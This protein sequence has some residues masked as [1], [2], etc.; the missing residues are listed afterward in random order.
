[1]EPS[2]WTTK[3]SIRPG[4]IEAAESPPAGVSTSSIRIAAT[5]ASRGVT[6]KAVDGKIVGRPAGSGPKDG[7]ADVLEQPAQRPPRSREAGTRRF[8]QLSLP[9]RVL[10]RLALALAREIQ[11]DERVHL[12]HVFRLPHRWWSSASRSRESAPKPTDANAKATRLTI[13]RIGSVMSMAGTSGLVTVS[14]GF[15]GYRLPTCV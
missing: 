6:R 8:A 1:M 9:A 15:D 5:L 12:P 3:R 11:R 4:V 14:D 2:A 10:R 13:A 7:G